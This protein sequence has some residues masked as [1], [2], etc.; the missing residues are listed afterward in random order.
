MKL[1]YYHEKNGWSLEIKLWQLKL[2]HQQVKHFINL[3][4]TNNL[5]V[6]V[7]NEVQK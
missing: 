1:K 3:V 6:F 4:L 5:Y 2:F 7:M